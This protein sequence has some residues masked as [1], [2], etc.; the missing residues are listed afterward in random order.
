MKDELNLIIN[1]MNKP[2]N[3]DALKKIKRMIEKQI[4]PKYVKEITETDNINRSAQFM[5][6]SKIILVNYEYIE[7]YIEKEA[8]A[9]EMDMLTSKKE[10]I[11]LIKLLTAYRIL[12]HEIHHAKQI[13]N[14][15]DAY[16]LDIE[17]EILRIIY[18][19]DREEYI[20][21]LKN[22]YK[23]EI[24]EEK[25]KMTNIVLSKYSEIN[26]IERK[27]EIESYKKI[28]KIIEPLK[29]IYPE[30]YDGIEMRKLYNMYNG[31]QDGIP[32]EKLI[33]IM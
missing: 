7:T 2:L 22:K 12:L 5:T 15:F 23:I 8:K 1:L 27:A 11:K 24:I 32:F 4:N 3:I 30:V 33:N 20:E 18:N 19:I 14:V 25:T 29:N 13:Y 21:Q 10:Y 6:S 26:P 28:K 31:Y 9:F 16:E 17:S